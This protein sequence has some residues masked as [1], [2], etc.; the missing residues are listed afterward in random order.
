MLFSLFGF[1]L[2]G[3]SKLISG[4][5]VDVFFALGLSCALC[6]RQPL[7][8]QLGLNSCSGVLNFTSE[9]S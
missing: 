6:S 8:F 7:K 4:L 1:N 3:A 5:L 9:H 2:T